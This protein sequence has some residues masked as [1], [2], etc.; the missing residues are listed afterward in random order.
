MFFKVMQYGYEGFQNVKA[1][2]K[3]HVATSNFELN[4]TIVSNKT[5][6]LHSVICSEVN[7]AS[8]TNKTLL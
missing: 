3:N 1:A 2:L 8:I 4:F 7:T 6:N 5:P